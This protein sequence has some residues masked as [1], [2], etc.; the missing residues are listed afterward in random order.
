MMNRI[1]SVFF[2]F[3][4]TA[5][6]TQQAPDSE[7][8]V[9]RDNSLQFPTFEP[10]LASRM[11]SV[12]GLGGPTPPLKQ[13]VAGLKQE[14][15][16]MRGEAGT[17]SKQ[18]PSAPEGAELMTDCEW[19][20]DDPEQ[21]I[22]MVMLPMLFTYLE[23]LWEHDDW[24]AL[25]LELAQV[26]AEMIVLSGIDLRLTFKKGE[27]ASNR[28]ELERAVR[29]FQELAL[30]PR[31]MAAMIMT[32]DDGPFCGKLIDREPISAADAKAVTRLGDEIELRLLLDQSLREPYVLQA[33]RR[34]EHLW[35]RVV[36][37]KG[38]V[39]EVEFIK[40][41]THLGAYGWKVHLLVDWSQGREYGHLYI[42][43]EGEFLFYY[44]SW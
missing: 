7:A 6:S 17:Q 14:L 9:E 24:S 26:A 5:C 39:K 40:E 18:Q 15:E 36:S 25:E 1:P 43:P 20:T 32:F 21:S 35:S 34:G 22:A 30:Q 37:G 23:P 41:P 31:G 13:L 16:R 29:W 12:S 2:A 38:S 28:A 33:F 42:G 11:K 8:A 27:A 44:L 4:I 10:F 3:A 19:L